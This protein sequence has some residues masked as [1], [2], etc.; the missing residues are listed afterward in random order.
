MFL[1]KNQTRYNTMYLYEI[2]KNSVDPVLGAIFLF[3]LIFLF[4]YIYLSYSFVYYLENNKNQCVRK[5]I[6][7]L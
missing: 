2:I 4:I 7:Y 1:E 6:Q 5:K 3:E